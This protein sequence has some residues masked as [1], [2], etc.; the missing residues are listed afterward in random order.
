MSIAYGGDNIT[1]PDASVQNTASKYGMIN[2]I[3]NGDMRIDQ[4][5]AGASITP[6]TSTTFNLDRWLTIQTVA[7]KFSIQQNAGAVT[8]PVGFTNYLGVTSLS[9]YSVL[10]SDYFLIRQTIEGFNVADLAWGTASAQPVTISF[11]VRSS[12]TG[13]FGGALQN[14]AGNRFYA[15]SYTVSAANTW[16]YK[17]ITISGD[18]SGVWLTNNGVGVHVTFGLGVGTTFSGAAGSWGSTAV[19]SATGATSVVGTNGATFYITGVSLVKG[20]VALPWDFRPYATELAL[21]QRYYVEG[22]LYFEGYGYNTYALGC[23]GNNFP[24]CMR[25][26]PTTVFHS[27]TNIQN[28]AVGETRTINS[29]A[30]ARYC[31]STGAGTTTAYEYYKASSE[32]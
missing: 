31:V 14:N 22:M 32:L 3:I 4:R 11:L 28:A 25:S 30:I 10:A 24:V 13:T 2:R 6:T 23:S 29:M 21:C 18:T 1:F 5:N 12:L 9:A 8:P 19:L 20:S 7:S 15:F 16:E 17:T 26:S 27:F